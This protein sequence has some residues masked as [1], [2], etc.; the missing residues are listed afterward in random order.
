MH[1][2]VPTACTTWLLRTVRD[3][4][5]E[6][7]RRPSVGGECA[8]VPETPPPEVADDGAAC[9]GGSG[10]WAAHYEIHSNKCWIMEGMRHVRW[11][12]TLFMAHRMGS[13]QQGG[14]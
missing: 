8:G 5:L 7:I 3:P 14:L 9:G 13:R 10:S 1:A 4:A 12:A 2:A 11:S 6:P